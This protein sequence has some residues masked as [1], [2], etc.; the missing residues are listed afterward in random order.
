[1]VFKELFMLGFSYNIGRIL[2]TN[3]ETICTALIAGTTVQLYG[4]L[5]H[6]SRRKPTGMSR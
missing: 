5:V 6:K 4:F 3:F 2:G 1:M